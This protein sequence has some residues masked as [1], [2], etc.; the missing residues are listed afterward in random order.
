MSGHSGSV[1]VWIRKNYDYKE[2]LYSY[3]IPKNRLKN[4]PKRKIEAILKVLKASSGFGRMRFTNEIPTKQNP[5]TI[6]GRHI[7]KLSPKNTIH[8]K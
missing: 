2:G 1:Q 5:N 3:I 8:N 6:I 4:A 7:N